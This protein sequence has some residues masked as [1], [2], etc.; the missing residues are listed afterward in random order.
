MVPVTMPEKVRLFNAGVFMPPLKF[1]TKPLALKYGAHALDAAAGDRYGNL[2]GLLPTTLDWNDADV[3]E[4]EMTGPKLT[5]L[6][7]R[8]PGDADLDVVLVV[9]PTG[10]VKT[11]WGNKVGDK[12][13]TLDRTKYATAL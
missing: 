5:K 10:F 1:P 8:V 13:K 12:H 9:L 11:T 6:V 4:V 7:C 2:L 3:V